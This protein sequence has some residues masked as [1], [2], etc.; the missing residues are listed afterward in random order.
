MCLAPSDPA[1]CWI[2][3]NPRQENAPSAFDLTVHNFGED[4]VSV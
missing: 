1:V 2:A 3:K 4:P